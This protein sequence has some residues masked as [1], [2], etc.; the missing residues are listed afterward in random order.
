MMTLVGG[1]V[2]I[3]VTSPTEKLTVAVPQTSGNTLYDVLR[4]TTTGTYDSGGSSGVGGSISFGQIAG[5]ILSC[6]APPP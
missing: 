5:N 6:E 2:G 1:K 3:G 4:I